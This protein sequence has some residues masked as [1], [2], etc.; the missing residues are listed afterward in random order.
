ELQ[1]AL[2]E[3]RDIV[4]PLGSQL[5]NII[6]CRPGLRVLVL[7]GDTIMMIRGGVA[8]FGSAAGHTIGIV[9]GSEVGPAGDT[10]YERKQR[11]YTVRTA[12]LDAA[13]RGFFNQP[14]P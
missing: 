12:D 11:P 10:P 1:L 9:G 4:A 3:A 7:L 2:E 8:N 5:L 6:A 14:A 13:C